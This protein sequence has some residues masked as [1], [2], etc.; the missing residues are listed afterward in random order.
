MA[1]RGETPQSEHRRLIV[2]LRQ[3][4]EAHQLTQKEVADALDWSAS[5]L[6][7]IEKGTVGISVTDLKALLA[8]YEITDPDEVDE[9]VQMAR[10]SKRTDWWQ[11]YREVIPL[12]FYTF[13]GLEASAVRIRQFQNLVVPGILQSPE[14]IK[15]LLVG[16]ESTPEQLQRGSE[17]RLRRQELISEQGPEFFFIIDESVLHRMVGGVAAMREQL[18]KLREVGDS[19][20]VSLRI[21]PFS[22]GVYRAMKSAYEILE[23]S[24]EYGD[25]ALMV[26]Q[27]YKDQLMQVPSDETGVYVSHFS[28]LERLACSEEETRHKLDERLKEIEKSG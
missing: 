28:R 16:A 1:P 2:A 6:I 12:D 13:L 7:R 17:V 5:K 11:K 20:R 27:G 10:A 19:P 15:A 22:V 24:E 4:R 9:M 8:H 21:L 25:Y 23:L 26:E 14:Y 18:L 3:A